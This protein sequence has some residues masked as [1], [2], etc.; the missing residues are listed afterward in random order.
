[1]AQIKWVKAEASTNQ[2]AV[3]EFNL[4]W[5]LSSFSLPLR[6]TPCISGLRFKLEFNNIDTRIKAAEFLEHPPDR[7]LMNI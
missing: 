7:Y 2:T 6:D 1:M 4:L 3:G 5:I